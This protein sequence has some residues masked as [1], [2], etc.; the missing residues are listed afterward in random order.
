MATAAS[1]VTADMVAMAAT[2]ASVVTAGMVVSAGMADTVDMAT[3]VSQFGD[4]SVLI[5]VFVICNMKCYYS[6]VD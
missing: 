6:L 5:Y 1:E 3:M 2:D 4:T